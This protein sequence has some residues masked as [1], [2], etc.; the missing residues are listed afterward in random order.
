MNGKKLDFLDMGDMQ[1]IN[2]NEGG[3][4]L[5]TSVAIKLY[6]LTDATGEVAHHWRGIA[7]CGGREGYC[8]SCERMRQCHDTVSTTVFSIPANECRNVVAIPA[9]AIK[10]NTTKL[11]DTGD[12]DLQVWG[13]GKD[14]GNEC[15][16]GMNH[17]QISQPG[18]HVVNDL[19]TR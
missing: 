13:P 10:F 17:C 15:L 16:V 4:G 2:I 5:K 8:K 1:S 9:G 7:P 19:I 3:E 18:E 6:A 12:V 11:T 14:G